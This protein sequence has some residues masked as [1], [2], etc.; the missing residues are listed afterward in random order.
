[1]GF[2][3]VLAALFQPLLNL[4]GLGQ[5]PGDKPM[6]LGEKIGSAGSK[7]G[8]GVAR[9]KQARYRTVM[10]AK[11]RKAMQQQARSAIMKRRGVVSPKARLQRR[12]AR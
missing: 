1:M 2:F 11:A 12:R 9:K 6:H 8:F 7:L 10:E 3:D 5:G 4:I